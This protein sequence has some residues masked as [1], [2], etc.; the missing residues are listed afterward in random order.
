MLI[1]Q[2]YLKVLGQVLSTLPSS[3]SK[4]Q[5][6]LN[7]KMS[8]T[9]KYQV[10]KILHQ[11]P[12]TSTLLDPNPA[13]N[14]RQSGGFPRSP[15]SQHGHCPVWRGLEQ[16]PQVSALILRWY[17]S[18]IVIKLIT[19][20]V[21][22]NTAGSTSDRCVSMPTNPSIGVCDDRDPPFFVV[23]AVLKATWTTAGK[24]LTHWPLGNF[25]LILGR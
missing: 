20:W 6:L 11:V 3:T 19:I 17:L 16:T 13:G 14:T 9:S 18:F 21:Y 1:W 23:R 5:V 24:L 12:S 10:L 8:S 22:S 2:K 25:N 4:Y 15:W 7:F